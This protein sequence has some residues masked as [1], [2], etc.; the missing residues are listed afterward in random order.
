[1][2]VKRLKV[3]LD[4]IPD[5]AEVVIGNNDPS[6]RYDL[7]IEKIIRKKYGFDESNEQYYVLVVKG[8]G[9]GCF[10]R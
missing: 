1:M 7:E 5:D 8:L 2:K 9:G 10:I 6:G 3:F 4:S